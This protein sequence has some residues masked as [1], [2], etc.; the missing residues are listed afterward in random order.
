M[1]TEGFASAEET[2]K[3][4]EE[5]LKIQAK[6]I[7]KDT[8]PYFV[9]TVRQ[10]LVKEL[11][12][13]V[14]LEQGLKIYTSLDLKAQVKAIETVNAG[15]RSIDKKRGYRGAKA[16]I[17]LEDAE[18][19]EKFLS[20]SREKLIKEKNSTLYLKADG[21]LVVF[22]PFAEIKKKSKDVK[23]I[24]PYIEIN[25]VVD[26]LVTKVDDPAGLVYVRFAESQGIIP[27]EEMLWARP[28]NPDLHPGEHLNIK[29]PSQALKPGD[30]V[31]VKVLTN[32]YAPAKTTL[33]SKEWY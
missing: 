4:G 25:E 18:A 22:E 16:Q 27:I 14:L 28:F 3:A 24:P 9:E 26:G 10:L 29:R 6:K 33:K 11:G 31:D 5:V 2:K 20:E 17:N 8:G 12:E 30:V 15:L 32:I 7:Y 13:E 19:V 1:T 23:N 21:T